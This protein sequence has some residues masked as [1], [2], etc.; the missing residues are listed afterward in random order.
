MA[1]LDAVRLPGYGDDHAAA[2]R[3]VLF[4]WW[5]ERFLTAP[6]GAPDIAALDA[7]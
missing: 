6:G 2:P 3:D 5:E 1:L 7:D 4:S